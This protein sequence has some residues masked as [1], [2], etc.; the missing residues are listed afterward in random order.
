MTD[1]IY[2]VAVLGGGA[3]GMMAAATAAERF[4]GRVV[5]L[6]RS[7]RLGK[8]LAA[9]GNGQGNITNVDLS[10][11]NYRGGD[12]DFC[13]YALEAFSNTDAVEFFKSMGMLTAVGERGKVYPASFQASSAVDLFRLR[14]K[15]LNVRIVT[16]FKAEKLDEYGGIFSVESGGETVRAESVIAACG[17]K[18]AKQ[19]GTDGSAYGLVEKFGHKITELSPSLVQLKTDTAFIKNLKGVRAE[20]V[21]RIPGGRSERGDVI[22]TD[23]GVSGSAVFYLSA[24]VDERT[25]EIVLEFLPDVEKEEI[26]RA[27]KLK[28]RG[29]YTLDELFAGIVHKSLGRSLLL[30]C[31]LRNF[32]APASAAQNKLSALCREL[33]NFR[34]KLKGALGFDYAQVTRGGVATE[35]VCDRTMMSKYKKNLFITGEMLDVDGECGGYNLQWAWSSG[36]LAGLN[37]GK[38]L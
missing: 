18:A 14:L 23:Y 11:K 37:A 7:D 2:K 16:G 13:R 6:E 1:K 12:K 4:G 28:M 34:L 21:V 10:E 3:S 20:A 30:K 8:K 27:L 25:E 17:G 35:G 38:V 22:F 9:S 36:R 26:L 31:G 19:F 5:L 15:N 33:K 32:G 24:D 29:G